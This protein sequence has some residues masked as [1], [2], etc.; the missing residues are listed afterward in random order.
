MN[1]YINVN[2]WKWIEGYS[3]LLCTTFAWC[4][5][6]WPALVLSLWGRVAEACPCTAPCGWVC[7][8][9]TGTKWAGNAGVHLRSNHTAC[10]REQHGRRLVKWMQVVY[11]YPTQHKF[12]LLPGSLLCTK[13]IIQDT[14]KIIDQS[15]R[16]HWWSWTLSSPP[17]PWHLPTPCNAHWRDYL[18]V[19]LELGLGNV[20][21]GVGMK[22][23][24]S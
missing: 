1:I 21:V 19:E 8:G 18:Q 10:R 16:Q 20:R 23:K 3:R 13:L 14:K 7:H 5:M 2:D 24:E 11:S 22:G 6:H 15:C 9:S 12:R 4:R 17:A